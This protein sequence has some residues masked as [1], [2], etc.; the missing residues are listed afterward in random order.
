MGLKG[1]LVRANRHTY[2]VV[3]AATKVSF[4]VTL[5][6]RERGDVERATRRLEPPTQRDH[7]GERRIHGDVAVGPTALT[8]S[9]PSAQ[10]VVRRDEVV[11]VLA[12]WPVS[13][14]HLTLPTKRIV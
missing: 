2:D 7:R 12:Q 6:A 10:R 14:T 8:R 1:S 11:N 4:A 5:L 13:Y 3:E 9:I